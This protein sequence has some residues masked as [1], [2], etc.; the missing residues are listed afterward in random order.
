MQANDG[1]GEA[2]NI[3]K[4]NKTCLIDI[5]FFSPTQTSNSHVANQVGTSLPKVYTGIA[6]TGAS[7]LY[8]APQAPHGP[9]TTEAP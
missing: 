6:D 4:Q 8:I 3:I 2:N 7:Y 5:I 9:I 1:G